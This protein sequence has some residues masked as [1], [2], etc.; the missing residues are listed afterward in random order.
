MYMARRAPGTKRE[1]L[2]RLSLFAGQQ[3]S[4]GKRRGR[5]GV[6]SGASV[7]ETA[8]KAG[9]PTNEILQEFVQHDINNYKREQNSNRKLDINY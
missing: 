1:S 5:G 6:I 4:A 2:H 9:K 7:S 3:R 8:G